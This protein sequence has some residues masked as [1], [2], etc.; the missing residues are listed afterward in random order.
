MDKK[1]P[2]AKI[3]C[4]LG[5]EP[6][7]WQKEVLETA[8]KRILLNCCRQAGKTT[9]AAMLAL[10]ETFWI[11]GSKTIIVS[12]SLRQST[13]LFKVITGY[14]GMLGELAKRRL[15]RGELEL[16]NGSRIV[17]LPCKEATI[18]GYANVSLIVIDEASRVPDDIYLAVRPMLAVSGGR[19]ICLS[20]PN[21]KSG[22][23]YQAWAQGGDDWLRIEVPASKI[24]RIKAEF[25]AK[26]E[27]GMVPCDYRREYCCSFEARAGL[28]YPD[29]AGCVV[30]GP[31]P[32]L[33]R[34]V[35][36][37]D[38]GYR[39][40]FAAVWG[41]LDH[42]GVLWLVSEHYRRET[43]LSMNAALLPKNVTWVCDP[44]G[45]N[46]RAE[47]RVLGFAINPGNAAVAAG[48]GAVQTR[49]RAG[50]LKIVTG[51]CPSLL[52]EAAVYHYDEQQ[53]QEVPVGENDH[54]LDALRYLIMRL[55]KGGLGHASVAFKPRTPDGE[56]D[57]PPTEVA[58][59]SAPPPRRKSKFWELARNE[60]VWT[61]L[62]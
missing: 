31:A 28:V 4:K 22:F 15:T 57:A 56:E 39:N 7:D 62:F 50:A 2:A 26:E 36:G 5:L 1:I 60:D 12:P 6:D 48:I 44:H 33:K 3:M 8:H 37:I 18:R 40:P 10:A 59:P 25:L 9:V 34:Q 52:A 55:D 42:D 27:R 29:M 20:T 54:A 14:Y 61:R 19:I 47:M 41:G 53:S 45:A 30:P 38:F 46:E 58:K 35:G 49:I 13:E 11:S 32:A 23:F 43:P 51:A 17:C 16:N 21:G 24:A